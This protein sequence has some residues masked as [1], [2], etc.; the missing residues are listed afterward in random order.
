MPSRRHRRTTRQSPARASPLL[1]PP[2]SGKTPSTGIPRSAGRKEREGDTCR[3]RRQRTRLVDLLRSFTLAD[4]VS[5]ATALSSTSLHNQP[6]PGGHT[7]RAPSKAVLMSKLILHCAHPPTGVFLSLCR[8]NK[9]VSSCTALMKFRA[10]PLVHPTR[11][12]RGR[13]AKGVYLA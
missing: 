4:T 11:T 8:K 1:Y 7:A 6:S 12:P 10:T 5:V 13:N 3:N 2:C 9:H